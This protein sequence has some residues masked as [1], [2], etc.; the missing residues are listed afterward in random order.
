MQPAA[1]V[2]VVATHPLPASRA[3]SRLPGLAIV[4]ALAALA[5]LAG[6]VLPLLGGAVCGIAIGVLVRTQWTPQKRH[7]SGIAF[8]TRTLLQVSVVLLGFGMDLGV[9]AR[10]GLASLPV[11]LLTLSV[12]FATAWWLGRALR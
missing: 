2:A 6:H 12:A 4:L 3:A 8:A 11:T 10:T 1:S 9:I 5:W 7:A